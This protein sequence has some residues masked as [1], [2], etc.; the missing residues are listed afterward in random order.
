MDPQ[1]QQQLEQEM[2]EA[3]QMAQQNLPDQDEEFWL[4]KPLLITVNFLS[5]FR[6]LI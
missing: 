3:D 6:T 5:N 2:R 1:Y 4:I